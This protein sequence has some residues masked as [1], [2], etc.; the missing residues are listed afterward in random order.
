M[1][2][3]ENWYVVPTFNIVCYDVSILSRNIPVFPGQRGA[4]VSEHPVHYILRNSDLWTFPHTYRT[5][6]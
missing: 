3:S 6:D 5:Q 4:K 1:Y 2:G